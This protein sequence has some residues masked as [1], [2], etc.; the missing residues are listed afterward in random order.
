MRREIPYRLPEQQIEVHLSLKDGR[1]WAK[2]HW[3]GAEYELYPESELSFFETEEGI[4]F[5]FEQSGEDKITGFSVYGG[6][7][8]FDK[9]E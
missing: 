5:E 6:A 1:L 4:T 8:Q 2:Q 3:D 7:Y 9:I